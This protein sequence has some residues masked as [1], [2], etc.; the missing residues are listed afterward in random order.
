ML[1]AQPYN[2]QL[3]LSNQNAQ[4]KWNLMTVE[5]ASFVDVSLPETT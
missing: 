2:N 3:P 1:T 4:N 5:S